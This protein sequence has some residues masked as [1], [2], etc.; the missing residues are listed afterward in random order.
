MG[1]SDSKLKES[2]S[3]QPIEKFLPK[4]QHVHDHLLTGKFIIGQWIREYY[5]GSMDLGIL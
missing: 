2:M 5:S 4:T 1:K 3:M